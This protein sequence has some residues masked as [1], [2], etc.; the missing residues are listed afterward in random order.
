[1]YYVLQ[2]I[3]SSQDC[4]NEFVG[5]SNKRINLHQKLIEAVKFYDKESAQN[6]LDYL[7]PCHDSV[8][9]TYFTVSK[10]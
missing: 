9:I 5:F 8:E 3:N 7:K 2:R 6:F 10:F 4:F 1:M